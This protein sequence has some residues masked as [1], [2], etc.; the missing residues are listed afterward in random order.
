MDE[1]IKH[2]SNI[3]AMDRST[4]VVIAVLCAMSAYVIKEFIANPI[5]VIFIFPILVLFSVLFQYLFLVAE[6]FPP[7]KLDQWL[8]WTIMAT[9]CGNIVGIIGVALA[10]RVRE[11]LRRPFARIATPQTRF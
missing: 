3:Y 1:L 5:M 11:S 10:G 7:K 9:I 8:M 2:L 6:L 4:L